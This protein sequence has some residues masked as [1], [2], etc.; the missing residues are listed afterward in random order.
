MDLFDRL[1]ADATALVSGVDGTGLFTVSDVATGSN[2]VAAS[3]SSRLVRFCV[4]SETAS[5]I[6]NVSLCVP[7]KE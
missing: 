3:L 2:V 6:L 4:L 5:P 1:G 7:S